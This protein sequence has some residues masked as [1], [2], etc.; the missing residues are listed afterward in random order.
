MAIYTSNYARKG[1]DPL[2]IAISR[3][4]P[5]WFHNL[6]LPQL[7][8]TWDMIMSMKDGRMSQN[9]FDKQ[10]IDLLE[11]QHINLNVLLDKFDSGPEHTYLLCYETP[12]D[13][14][15]RHLF[16]SWIEQKTGVIISE[17][18]NPKEITK[19]HQDKVV[20]NLLSF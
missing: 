4:P 18:L 16:S 12:T 15:H 17:W 9:Q 1:H 10:Y 11:N 5:A 19:H 13:F 8:P 20:D 2:A 6:H 3:T 7:A 14:C